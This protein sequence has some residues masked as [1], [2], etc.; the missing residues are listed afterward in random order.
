[1]GPL[2]PAH[3]PQ[4]HPLRYTHTS[5]RAHVDPTI[6]QLQWSEEFNDCSRGVNHSKWY[7]EVGIYRNRELQ[8]YREENARCID[9]ALVFSS[10]FERNHLLAACRDP[11][12]N[13]SRECSGAHQPRGREAF[14]SGSIVSR[15]SFTFG[16]YDAR[17]RIDVQD[18]SWPAF[19][20]TGIRRFG[21]P[22]DGGAPARIPT[23]RT[24]MRGERNARNSSPCAFA[25]R[26]TCSSST[27]AQCSAA[28]SLT[29]RSSMN[30]VGG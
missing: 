6:M 12:R 13:L 7:H 4:P 24:R 19:W 15:D 14:T 1:M 10:Q 21:W 22:M 11:G 29:R 25:Q 17:I 5:A 8:S 26:R 30:G 20:L 28:A 3:Q 2:P 18:A 16:Q 23:P 27:P 9:G